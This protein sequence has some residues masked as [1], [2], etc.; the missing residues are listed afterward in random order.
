[1]ARKIRRGPLV[2]LC[3]AVLSALAWGPVSAPAAAPTEQKGLDGPEIQPFQSARF[4]LRGFV[5]VDGI[6]I[7]LSG[8]G[9]MAPPDRS[10]GT[11]KI[12]PFTLESVAIRPTVFFRTRFDPEWTS[13]STPGE[14]PFYVGP[15]ALAEFVPK[16]GYSVLGQDRVDGKLATHWSTELDLALLLALAD[17]ASD[18][19]DAD[20]R[21][22]LGTV[23]A[24]LEVWVG[25]E[26]RMVYRERLLLTWITPAIEPNGDPLPSSIDITL[27]YTRLN[28]PVSIEAPVPTPRRRPAFDFPRLRAIGETLLSRQTLQPAAE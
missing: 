27:N 22:A 24:A 7:D 12:G 14:L 21:E 2:A 13:D 20:V 17:L 18:F 1:M 10:N 9:A 3:I 28:Q 19:N 8:E 4:D 11:Y 26:D 23:R 6:T 25:N 15:A 16:G 5:K